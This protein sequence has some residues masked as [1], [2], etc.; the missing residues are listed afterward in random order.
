MAAEQSAVLCSPWRGFD[1][2]ADHC[3]ISR[4]TLER[5][6]KE[7]RGPRCYGAG[8]RRRLFHVD[9]LDAWVRAQC[10]SG[11]DHA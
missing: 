2:A 10:R 6:L 3:R 9:D 11:G 7:G 8:R 1:E 4:S 5:A